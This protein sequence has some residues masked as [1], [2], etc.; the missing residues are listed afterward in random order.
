[1]RV[2]LIEDNLKLVQ[3][4][5]QSLGVLGIQVEAEGDGVLA[6][7]ALQQH[8]FDVVVLDL[9]LPRMGGIE[10]L[11]RMRNRGDK[12]PVL[13]LTATGDT[14]DRVHGLNA[15]A[16]DYLP[17]PFDLSELEARLRALHRRNLGAVHSVLRV[18]SLEYDTVSRRFTID[19]RH[20]EL[21]PREHDLLEAL[22]SRL[23]R[24]V[25]KNLLADGLR[26]SDSVLSHDALEVYVHRLRRRLQ[27]S[28]AAIHTVRGL[29]Y[30]LEPSDEAPE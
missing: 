16:D 1:M 8:G 17:K 14:S 25:S 12:V 22:I 30:V 2:L 10:V 19:A 29:G 21:P 18:G 9:A 13:V 11:R 27:G 6:D 4:L 28:G 24:P 23:S 26:S 7:A 20:L 3:T 5:T 15:G